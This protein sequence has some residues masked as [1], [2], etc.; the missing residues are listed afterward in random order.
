MTK[1]G[2]ARLTVLS[3]FL[4]SGKTTW[5][6]HQ[7]RH[8]ALAG[9][10]LL[11]NEAADAPVDD[12]LLSAP[13][14]RLI[15][16]GCACCARRAELLDALNEMVDEGARHIVLETSGL[17]DPAAIREAVQGDPRLEGRLVLGEIV[18][19]VDCAQGLDLLRTETTARRQVGAAD[20]LIV[21][22]PALA[23]ID[24][25]RRLVATL[26]LMAPQTPIFAAERGVDVP[27]PQAG[28]VEPE[29][30][31]PLPDEPE[32]RGISA[33]S[34]DLSG[35]ADWPSFALWISALLYARGDSVLRVKGIL[36]DGERRILVQ[37]T[38]R[39]IEAVEIAGTPEQTLD[40]MVLIG[41]GFSED[42]LYRSLRAFS[43]AG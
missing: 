20:A 37:A 43:Q 33:I 12:M 29:I 41:R 42:D 36:R 16:G 39:A 2:P 22:K 19:T 6:A 31:G 24:G 27:A 40:R 35:K 5:L 8:G 10:S 13:G 7:I 18:V 3:G 14:I 17:A 23:E 30:F 11:V 25:A 9:A 26:Q 32:N 34:L 4:G 38:R 15:A 21:T 28:D 1:Q